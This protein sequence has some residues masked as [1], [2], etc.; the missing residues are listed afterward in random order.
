LS[1]ISRFV[2]VTCPPS[3]QVRLIASSADAFVDGIAGLHFWSLLS[4]QEPELAFPWLRDQHHLVSFRWQAE[5]LV[6]HVQPVVL[7]R[8]SPREAV[9]LLSQLRGGRCFC[10]WFERIAWDARSNA[11]A[12]LRNVRRRHNFVFRVYRQHDR[13]N[14]DN[15]ETYENADHSGTCQKHRSATQHPTRANKVHRIERQEES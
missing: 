8:N 4:R 12:G 15:C 3:R 13:I 9:E 14:T 10:S 6:E 2:G 7:V 5:R 11:N 1:G